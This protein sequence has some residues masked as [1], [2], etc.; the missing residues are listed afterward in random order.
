MRNPV[1]GLNMKGCFVDSKKITSL[2]FLIVEDDSFQR[3]A[4][5]MLLANLGARHVLHAENGRAALDI[6]Q[7]PE[8]LVDILLCDLDM[9]EMDGM[10][11][12]RKLA[13]LN[14]ESAVI[15]V[16]G[17]GAAM[18]DSVEAMAKAYGLDVLGTMPKP[19][20]RSR[21]LVLLENHKSGHK[22]KM[23]PQSQVVD[24]PQ[25]EFAAGLKRDE[26]LPYFQPKVEMAS[27][28]VVGVE[29]LV[30]WNS[31]T[32]GLLAPGAFLDAVEKYGLMDHLTWIILAKSAALCRHWQ[33]Q[34]LSL[35][36]SVNLS[37]S[38]LSRVE[39]AECIVEVV[40]KQGL[41][42]A[43]M[44]L[45]VTESAA[46]SAIGPSLENLTRLRLR[47]FGLSIDDY[48]T[49]YSSLQ[50]LTRVPFTELKIDQSFVKEASQHEAIRIVV[51]SSLDIAR[52]LGLKV[53]AEGI[54]T[55]EHW[56]MLSTM[57]C[58]LAQGY[59]IA[60]PMPAEVIP[61][62]VA[63]WKLSAIQDTVPAPLAVDILLVEDEDFQRETYAELLEQLQLGRVD[64]AKDVDEALQRLAAASYGLVITDV[65]LGASSGLGL[66]RLI[67]SQQTPTSPGTRILLL[68]SHSEQDVV[69]QSI[70]LDING[71]LTKP[72]KARNLHEAVQ[73]A[74]AEAFTPQSPAYYL[75][76]IEASS[77]EPH[78]SAS[79][80]R[81]AAQPPPG[82]HPVESDQTPLI[83]MK[84]GMV[85]VEPIY[86]R[87][88]MLVLG[89]GNVL[90]QSIINRLL[91][92]RDS[93]ASSDVWVESDTS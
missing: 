29:A 6:L 26:F 50:Q 61:G 49:G 67:R 24:I 2:R 39:L 89:R 45:E 88:K 27:G 69:L 35:L 91:E 79:I 22:Q 66:V 47:G 86:T 48:G 46:M 68:S 53:T 43:D 5:A 4:L 62:W 54:E 56:R 19:L 80:S 90:T 64:T 74:L 11:C 10:A 59:L 42:P 37:L 7:D 34:G 16:S 12:L 52:K 73:Q 32:R 14:R 65:D 57:G 85:L 3:D 25:H 17:L 93:L 1:H 30:R 23:R 78:V 87:D 9:P 44:I 60:K 40:A 13:A 18:L 33:D 81:S 84:A 63:G 31:P 76:I 41:E 58:D 82:R 28:R 72:A 38:S 55:P 77:S 20:S 92:V 8:V 70:T 83:A 75:G 51:E 15:L 36:L 71:F 21:L